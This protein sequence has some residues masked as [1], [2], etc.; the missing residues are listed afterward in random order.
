MLYRPSKASR[1]TAFPTMT[2]RFVLC[3]VVLCLTSIPHA[4][5]AV[6]PAK[7]R[8]V[9]L[10]ELQR[11][12]GELADGPHHSVFRGK[13][14]A[15]DLE[16][17]TLGQGFERRWGIEL[18]ELL[19]VEPSSIAKIP[20]DYEYEFPVWV[21]GVC[22]GTIDVDESVEHPGEFVRGT[23]SVGSKLVDMVVPVQE[24][25]RASEGFDVVVI[26]AAGGHY[27]VV[28]QK[29]AGAILMAPLDRFSARL[30]GATDA[31]QSEYP[32]V[33][34]DT[35]L[36]RIKANSERTPTRQDHE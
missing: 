19:S 5:D 10:Q 31:A 21:D 7:A 2:V 9:A 3:F 17:A 12:R 22:I 33:D 32:L 4:T 28:Q 1:F 27:L 36:R 29:D 6:V 11:L 15:S 13:V 20:C 34:I 14:D 25:Y 23:R 30:I 24:R 18:P 26:F 16:R 35:A 8:T